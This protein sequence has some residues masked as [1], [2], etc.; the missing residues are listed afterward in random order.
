MVSAIINGWVRVLRLPLE[1]SE[2]ASPLPW[3]RPASRPSALSLLAF[4]DHLLVD[5][6]DIQPHAGAILS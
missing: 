5:H 1:E 3:R 4:L 2:S 6:F